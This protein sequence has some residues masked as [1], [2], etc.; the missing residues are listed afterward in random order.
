LTELVRSQLVLAQQNRQEL[1]TLTTLG[2]INNIIILPIG[3]ALAV[4]FLGLARPIPGQEVS[5]LRRIAPWMALGAVVWLDLA[6]MGQAAVNSSSLTRFQYG[7]YITGQ[8]R[9]EL[10]A[11]AESMLSKNE[12]SDMHFVGFPKLVFA[13]AYAG[14]GLVALL[15]AICVLTVLRRRAADAATYPGLVGGW[16]AT[17]LVTL[18]TILIALPQA[19]MAATAVSTG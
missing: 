5:P 1:A 17:L 8:A 19:I 2:I 11:P 9:T 10:N 4:V 6:L 13:A 18:L 15:T 3:I 12:Y 7:S 14:P 16:R